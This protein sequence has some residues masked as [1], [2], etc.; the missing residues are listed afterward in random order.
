MGR[1]VIDIVDAGFG[2]AV[3]CL[4]KGVVGGQSLIVVVRR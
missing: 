1:G 3:E 4:G 2:I